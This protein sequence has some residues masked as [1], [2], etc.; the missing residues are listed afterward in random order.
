MKVTPTEI[1]EV[2][3][4]EPIV[5]GD[6]R[7]FFLE[8]WCAP[9]YRQAG[10][11]FNFVQD[12]HSRS[13][14]GTLRGLH[15]QL[16]PVAEAKL[17]RCTSGAIYEVIVDMRLESSTYLSYVGVELSQANRTS[18]RSLPTS[19]SGSAPASRTEAW[20]WNSGLTG[21]RG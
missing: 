16:A 3:L 20:P 18:P 13:V 6:G 5:H 19:E 9:R 21:V 10:I 2:L 14:A 11:E 8:T 1:P 12:N 17:I 7:G 15:Y 4:V